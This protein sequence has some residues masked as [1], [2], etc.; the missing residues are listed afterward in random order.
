MAASP[1]TKATKPAEPEPTA[2]QQL[3]ALLDRLD[4]AS[5][6]L[7]RALRAAF[8]RRFPTAFEIVYDYTRSLVIAVGPTD[9]GYEATFTI[10]AGADGT[11]LYFLNGPKLPDPQQVLQGE[12]KQVRYVEIPTIATL[13]APAIARLIAEATKLGKP[14]PKTGRGQLIVKAT[15]NA[16]RSAR[17]R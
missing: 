3:D 13:R 4:P 14:M 15:A 9:R 1:R 2:A 8:R 16:K 10:A 12:G 17:K 6:K 5:R 7:V 11:K